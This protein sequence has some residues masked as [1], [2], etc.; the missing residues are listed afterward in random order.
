MSLDFSALANTPRLLLEAQ[1]QP[2]QGT[3]FQPTGFPNL[4]HATYDGPDG[5]RMLLVES[6]QSMANR[7]EAVCW[8]DVANDWVAALKGLPVIKV[9]DKKGVAL[10]NTVLESHRINSPYILEGK[11][12]SVLDRLKADLAGMEEGP[13]DIRKLAGV[14]LQLDVNALIHGVFLAK[15]ELAGG[16]LRLPRVLSSFIEAYD[17]REAQSGG[18]KLDRVR[19]NKAGEDQSS[20]EGFGNVPFARSEFTSP[21]IVAYFNLDLAQIRAFGLGEN[22]TRLL[23]ALSLYKIQALLDGGLRLRSAC[24][25]EVIPDA[26]ITIKRPKSGFSLPSRAELEAALPALVQAVAAERGW[27]N[28]VTQVV[29]EASAKAKKEKGTEGAE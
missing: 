4:G 12:R 6:A 23:I 28:P 21:K 5:A 8:D 15:S 18:V 25:L 13:V 3:R 7:L 14:L 29:W 26:G 10:T 17:V 24:D 27:S 1:L 19:P 11:D 22:A 20:R 2:L 16:R 9:V